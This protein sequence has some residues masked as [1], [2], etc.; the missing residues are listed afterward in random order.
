MV[1]RKRGADRFTGFKGTVLKIYSM[2]FNE[3]LSSQTCVCAV[4][5]SLSLFINCFTQIQVGVDWLLQGPC[6]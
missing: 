5:L 1:T 2:C 6:L 3:W 4:C